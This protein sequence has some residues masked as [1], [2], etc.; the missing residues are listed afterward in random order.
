MK[1]LSIIMIIAGLPVI[2]WG[3]WA[4]HNAKKPL[5]IIGALALPVGL[6]V[7]LLGVLLVCVPNF[8]KG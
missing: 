5:D 2:G 1:T 7:S 6:I 4:S 3:F 8:F